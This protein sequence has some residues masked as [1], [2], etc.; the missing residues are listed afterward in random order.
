[1]DFGELND[2]VIKG[3]IYLFKIVSMF[4]L[5]IHELLL[6]YLMVNGYYMAHIGDDKYIDDPK[7]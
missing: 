5:Y 7:G 2:K 3:L 1:V 4:Y 6:E